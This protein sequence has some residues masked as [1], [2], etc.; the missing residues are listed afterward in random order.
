[1]RGLT[2]GTPKEL[3]PVAGV[4]VLHLVA[5]ECAASGIQDV[6][7]VTAPDKPAIAESLGPLAGTP[8]MP[9]RIHFVTQ[10]EPRGLAD[11]IRLSRDFAGDEPLAVALPDNLFLGDLPGVAQVVESYVRHRTNVVSV[12]EIFAAEGERYGPTAVLSG[13]A[14]GD[15]FQLERIPDKGSPEATFDTRGAPSAFTAVGRF[16]FEPEVFPAIDEVERALRLGA[17]LD[18][19]PLLQLLLAR[20][21]LIG[22]RMR[23]RFLDIGLPAGYA[24]AQRILTE[25]SDAQ[26]SRGE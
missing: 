16:V 26:G 21:R 19:V 4:P 5:Q 1:M 13:E 3:L 23:G 15:D 22:R 17:E 18:N 25:H 20:G 11:A 24:E 14:Q 2:G 12:V 10:P 7:V 9:E 8:A 6:L